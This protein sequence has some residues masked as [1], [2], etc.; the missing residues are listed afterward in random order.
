MIECDIG[1]TVIRCQCGSIRDFKKRANLNAL[2]KIRFCEKC[3]HT[4]RIL[5]QMC[6]EIPKRHWDS[7]IKGCVVRGLEIDISPKFIWELFLTQH[8]QCALTGMSLDFASHSK[9]HDRGDFTASLDRI[10]CSLGYTRANV[11][12]VHKYVNLLK[13]D[14]SDAE[15]LV[16]CKH[17]FEKQMLGITN[18]FERP[19]TSVG[20]HHLWR[21]CGDIGRFYWGSLIDKACR[22]G[23]SFIIPIEHGWEMLTKQGFACAISGLP[24]RMASESEKRRGIEETASLDRINSSHGYIYGNVQW[25]HKAVNRMKKDYNEDR[26]IDLCCRIWSHHV[27]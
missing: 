22:R 5:E 3:Y 12:W 25:V 7:L 9:A 8:R 4:S 26:F 2:S 11:R 6:G 20:S 15:L 16:V 23:M 13:C 1:K 24:I 21:G 10:D 14:H 18:S 19:A 27:K 17:I